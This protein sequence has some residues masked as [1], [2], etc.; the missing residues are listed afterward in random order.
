MLTEAEK[1]ARFERALHFAGDTHSV[2]DV[3][4]KV[5]EGRAQFFGNDDA[6]VVAEVLSYPKLRAVNLWLVSGELQRCL[7]LEDQ[8]FDWGREN[9]C[10]VGTATGRRGW[11]RVAP[12]V[13]WRLR[14]FSFYKPLNGGNQ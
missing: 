5:R 6:C 9:G 1:L 12:T 3:I 4:E 7:A 11:L 10:T 2:Q 14:A 8:I 13:G